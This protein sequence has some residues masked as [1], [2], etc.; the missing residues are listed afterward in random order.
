M[1]NYDREPVGSRP[2]QPNV[3]SSMPEEEEDKKFW[4]NY[5]EVLIPPPAHA[6][7]IFAINST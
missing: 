1:A 5:V 6:T 4:M 2:T 7:R 3:V